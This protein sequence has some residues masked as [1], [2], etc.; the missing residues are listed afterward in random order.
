MRLILTKYTGAAV[1]ID[2]ST[3]HRK[4]TGP[5]IQAWHANRVRD[6]RAQL[7]LEAQTL[8][9]SSEQ[10]KRAAAQSDVAA[11]KR[12]EREAKRE[13]LRLQTLATEGGLETS[14]LAPDAIPAAASIPLRPRSPPPASEASMQLPAHT[15]QI[16]AT[17]SDLAWYNPTI[18]TD[19]ASASA[20]NIWVYPS[21]H[22]ERARCA[23]FRDLS[24]K[25]YYMGG[26]LRFGGDW[27]V[28]PGM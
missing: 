25:G 2:D 1:L 15:V 24:E 8:N 10:A 23:I 5:E 20:A 12:A 14:V 18:Y 19:L 7:A 16:P 28:Y 11:R 22:E 4:P 26:G 21:T 3:S 9:P 13:E 6:T 17:S 27:L